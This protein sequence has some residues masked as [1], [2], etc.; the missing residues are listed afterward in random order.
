M[1]EEKR[2]SS[3]ASD[4]ETRPSPWAHLWESAASKLGP[5]L[6]SLVV[7]VGFVAFAGKA[8]LWARFSAL[9]VPPDQVVKAVPEGEAV[10]TGGSM[11]LLFG[12]VG[13]LAALGVYL[14]DRGG[15]ATPGM[16]RGLLAI[17]AVEA[18]VAIWLAEGKSVESQVIASEVAL[19]AI[20]VIFWSTF[21]HG[22]IVRRPGRHGD[23]EIREQKV[24]AFYQEPEDGD[25]TSGIKPLGAILAV[26]AAV[27]LGGAVFLVAFAFGASGELATIIAL[28]ALAAGLVGAIGFHLSRFDRDGE[29]ERRTEAIE[30]DEQRAKEERKTRAKKKRKRA[31]K[32][33]RREADLTCR[34]GAQVGLA[35]LRRGEAR[36]HRA[37]AACGDGCRD[38]WQSAAARHR[39][40]MGG[41]RVGDPADDR[42]RRGPLA[43]PGGVVAGRLARDDRHPRDRAVADLDLRLEALRLVWPGGVR[44][45][46]A[47]RDGDA[48]GPQHR[49][50]PGAADGA[51]PQ[52]RRP[53]RSYPG[54]VRHRN[55]QPGLLRQRRHRRL[56]QQD[57]A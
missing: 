14:V 8:V 53:R 48:D 43:D 18:V 20:A 44:L 24:R 35:L 51:D 23:G 5:A 45:R 46:A 17:L 29:E 30:A 3:K 49:R 27:A 31:E 12:L 11:L 2:A 55:Q 36:S 1:G 6:V 33:L 21:V 40:Q 26:G 25:P 15:R 42:R 57:Q 16:S 4:G 32:R 56:R 50:S 22:L 13:L 47:V 7:S 37:A 54:A 41:R 9:Q 10:A 38:G 34:A 19:L 28:P 39:A 52:H